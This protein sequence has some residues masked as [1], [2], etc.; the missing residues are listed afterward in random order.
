MITVSTRSAADRGPRPGP[1][2]SRSV[3]RPGCA[4]GTRRNSACRAR[5][6]SPPRQPGR[7]WHECYDEQEQQIEPQEDRIGPREPVGQTRVSEPP[8]AN[9]QEADGVREEGW[10]GVQ[11]LL[12]R[13]AR[14]M[15]REVDHEQRAGE[16]E[17]AVAECLHPA[18][19]ERPAS[20]RGVLIPWHGNAPSPRP[21]M[22]TTDDGNQASGCPVMRHGITVR[23]DVP[24]KR[25][26]VTS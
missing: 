5:R 7:K 10:P 17:G 19:V 22:A 26:A 13:R 12:K 23:L 20:A 2:R 11:Q 9:R 3:T 21:M 4:C 24:A 18:L 14:R 15:E 16:S 6:I 25:W 8:H 1:H